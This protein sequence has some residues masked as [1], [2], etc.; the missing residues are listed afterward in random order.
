LKF[1]L[2]ILGGGQLARMSIMAAQRMGYSC[3]SLDPAIETPAS[4]ISRSVAGKLDDPVAISKIL[5]NCEYVTLENEFIPAAAIREA[6]QESGHQESKLVPGISALETIQDKLVQRHTFERFGIASPKAFPIDGEGDSALGDLGFPLVLKSRFGGY[7]GKGVRIARNR[8]E[9]NSHR[10]DWSKGGWLAEEFVD[11]KRELAVMVYITPDSEGAFPTMVTVQTKAVCDYVFPAGIDASQVAISA[12]KAM[13][14]LGLF[15]VELFELDSGEILVNE[16]A[17]RPHNT[18]HYTLDWGGVSQF[19]QHV[20]VVMGLPTV[21]P[22]GEECCMANLLGQSD[23]D[24]FRSGIRA[25]LCKVPESK[26]HWYGKSQSR[27]GR[28]MGHLNVCGD[29]CVERALAARA[30]FYDSV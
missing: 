19:E 2:G 9:F 5:R 27:K 14:S 3:L 30:A 11:F 21:A 16:I 4:K 29:N 15:G 23:Y 10:V 24:D 1:D 20:R 22:I 17:P 8:E 6:L 7:D 13:G 25:T 18:G 26:V 12:V 28:K